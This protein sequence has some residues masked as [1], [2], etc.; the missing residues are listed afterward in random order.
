MGEKIDKMKEMGDGHARSEA[1]QVKTEDD[2][3][4]LSADSSSVSNH[5]QQAVFH[6]AGLSAG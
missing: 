2:T 5:F 3:D 4:Y 6:E 1:V